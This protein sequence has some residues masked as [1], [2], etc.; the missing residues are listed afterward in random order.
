VL[1]P[2]IHVLKHIKE[3][4]LDYEGDRAECLDYLATAFVPYDRIAAEILLLVLISSPTSRPPGLPPLGALSAN[5]L[6]KIKPDILKAVVPQ[7]V[8]LPLSIRLLQHSRFYPQSLDAASLDSGLLQLGAGTVLF[9]TEE[10][11]GEGGNLEGN[12]LNNL[13]TLA[14]V[15]ANQ[16]LR[17]DY[18]YMPD[19]QIECALRAVICSERKS[20]IPVS[21]T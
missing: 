5:F 21:L 19:L 2:A 17:Y 10:G 3:E 7:F 1:V 20:L 18:P 16:T 14:D 15:I 6:G 9:V 13:K 4:S 11:M 12:A 8:E